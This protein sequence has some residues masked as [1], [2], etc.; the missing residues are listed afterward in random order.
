M[1]GVAGL[2]RKLS[3]H[4]SLGPDERLLLV[5]SFGRAQVVAARHDLSVDGPTGRR[6][7]L[8]E[9]G[10]AF[11]YRILPDGSRQVVEIALAGDVLGLCAIELEET[12]IL[13]ATVSPAIVREL[14]AEAVVRILRESPVLAEALIRD[15]AVNYARLVERLTDVGRRTATERVAHFMLDLAD[16]A[17][18]AGCGGPDRF[19]CPLSQTLIADAIGLTAIHLNRVLRDLRTGRMLVMADGVVRILNRPAL[20]RLSGGGRTFHPGPAAEPMVRAV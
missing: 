7:F 4:R 9:E 11:S 3:A 13:A 14:K 12:D 5:R 6:A 8:I 16:R 15:A 10:W 19:R 20:E 18:A 1:V 2:E 17:V